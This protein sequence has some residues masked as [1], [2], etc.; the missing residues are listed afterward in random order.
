MLLQYGGTKDPDDKAACGLDLAPLFEEGK[1]GETSPAPNGD[2]TNQFVCIPL[3]SCRPQDC[4]LSNHA[5]ANIV[6]STLIR[7]TREK[8][9][10]CREENDY[11]VWCT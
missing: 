7:G 9:A 2:E 11:E 8:L 5:A 6:P 10:H 3:G 4:A 1:L